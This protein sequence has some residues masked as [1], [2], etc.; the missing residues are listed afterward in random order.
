MEFWVVVAIGVV[1]GGIGWWFVQRLRKQGFGVG[2]R[3]S[4]G[5]SG[6]GRDPDLDEGEA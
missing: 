1:G 3:D 6:G 5:G 2:F 4:F